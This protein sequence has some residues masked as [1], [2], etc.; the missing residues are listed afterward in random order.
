MSSHLGKVGNISETRNFRA[1]QKHLGNSE[2]PPL[3]GIPFPTSEMGMPSDGNWQEKPRVPRVLE[4][5]GSL[6]K[7]RA[8][9]NPYPKRTLRV[10]VYQGRSPR[11]T[12]IRGVETP[13]HGM[14]ENSTRGRAKDGN[15]D[16]TGDAH[17]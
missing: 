17:G 11:E 15:R 6:G 8:A 12:A 5:G 4:K 7:R 16:G 2:I 14:A 9:A 10:R 1:T 13:A 3:R